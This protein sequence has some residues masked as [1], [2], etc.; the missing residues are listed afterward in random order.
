MKRLF[1]YAL[2]LQLFAGEGAESADGATGVED[3]VAEQNSTTSDE[4]EFSQLI[5][6]KFKDQFTKKTQAIID[7]RFKQTKELEAYKS[8]ISPVIEKLLQDYGLQEG[9]EELLFDAINSTGADNPAPE[10]EEAPTV[11]EAP[12]EDNV[13]TMQASLR[14][15]I[16]NWVKES[17]DFKQL[18]P[19]FDLRQEL[20]GNPLFSKMLMSGVPLK[21]AYETVHRD[22]FLS[23]AMQYTAEAVRKQMSQSIAAKGRRPVENGISGESAVVTT[24]DVNSLTS[25]DILKILKQ[26]ENG[27]S[28]SF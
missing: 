8:K 22:E 5:S 27:A 14:G 26:V 11:Q 21:V 19:Q 4:D 24:V 25:Q 20:R 17:E 13:P 6:G 23:G 7:K 1:W 3:A 28:I 18:V 10:V 9:Q 12:D 16:G 15:K 2:N